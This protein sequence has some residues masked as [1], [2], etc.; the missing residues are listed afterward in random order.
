M[1]QALR[2]SLR[3][4]FILA[5]ILVIVHGAA[6][7]VILM[8]NMPPW[9]ALIAI[10]AL[11]INLG[12]SIWRNALT[13][14]GNAVV[15]I[16]VASDTALSIR[17]RRGEWLECEV[18]GDTYVAWFL[19]VLNLRQIGTGKR[20]SVAILPDAIDAEDFRRLRVWLRWHRGTQSA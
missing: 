20:L 15:E 1:T 14:G 11:V 7:A 10:A 16:G 9:L 19:T 18:R 17:T 12:V 8:A 13:R 3:P 6:I 5:A 2:V 4:S